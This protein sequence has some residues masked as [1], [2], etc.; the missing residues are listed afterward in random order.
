MAAYMYKATDMSGSKASGTINSASESSAVNSLSKQG[1]VVL[2]IREV[3]SSKG[4]FSL[5]PL[6]LA[7]LMTFSRQLSIM[8]NSGVN[9]ASALEVL[10]EQEVFSPRFRTTISTILVNIESGM[11]FAEALRNEKG[12]DDIFI[13]LVDVGENSGSLETT[14]D[15]VARFYES[16]KK[17]K[18]EVKSA[19]AYPMFIFVFGILMVIVVMFFI[20]PKLAESFG[21][22]PSGIMG[23]LM[24]MNLFIHKNW[25]MVTAVTITSTIGLIFFFLSNA[26]KK[27]IAAVL[28]V[29]PGVKQIRL[30]S[31]LERYCRTLSV[32]ISSGVDI[33]KALSLSGNAANDQRFVRT[34]DEMSDDIRQ[35]TSLEVAFQKSGIFPGL[36]IAMVGTGERTGKLDEIL[37]QV[38]DFFEEKVRTLVKQVTAIIEP[39]MIVLV[40]IF[41][42]FIAYAMYSSIFQ[43][44]QSIT[45]GF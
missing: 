16:Q 40:G 17:L 23:S 15:K 11:S 3:K 7:D 28:S 45:S 20:L 35:G 44:Q 14:L 26:G 6:K 42:A 8:I 37:E 36:I 24:K 32:M 22:E 21:G 5:F 2:S 43:G 13:N 4:Q 9:L 34:V 12:F 38:A 25:I 1:L 31:S 10:S 27:F 39:M 19:T 41:I 18:D 33:I 29:I 30:N